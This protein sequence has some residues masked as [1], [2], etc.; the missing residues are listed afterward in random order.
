MRV[1]EFIEWLKTQDQDAEVCVVVATEGTGYYHTVS[2]EMDEF[3]VEL[4]DY[5]ENTPLRKDMTG[6]SGVLLLGRLP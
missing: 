4:A 6:L 3:R 5:A 1:S 2:V